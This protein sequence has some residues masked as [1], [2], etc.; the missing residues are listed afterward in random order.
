MRLAFVLLI[1][2]WIRECHIH[3]NIYNANI[4][5]GIDFLLVWPSWLS[6]IVL[7]GAKCED[8]LRTVRD[9]LKYSRSL[10]I[11]PSRIVHTCTQHLLA[12]WV[13][14]FPSPSTKT[15]FPMLWILVGTNANSS[16][17]IIDEGEIPHRSF[18][19]CC[20]NPPTIV[21]V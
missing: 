14:C 18:I 10:A 12:C 9:V 20:H 17:L 21:N 7:Q 1:S 19:R 13:P 8:W 2:F 11:L 3:M 6:Q 4:R 16:V 5:D 15:L